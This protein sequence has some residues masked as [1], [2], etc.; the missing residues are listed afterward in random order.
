MQR[1][2]SKTVRVGFLYG[3]FGSDFRLHDL[4]GVRVRNVDVSN[5]AFQPRSIPKTCIQ[6]HDHARNMAIKSKQVASLFGINGVENFKNLQPLR[7]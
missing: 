6:F 4:A 5:R 7:L 2:P 3:F 1:R